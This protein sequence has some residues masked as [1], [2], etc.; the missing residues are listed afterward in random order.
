MEQLW[1]ESQNFEFALLGVAW[2]EEV[3]R[4]RSE[5]IKRLRQAKI[6]GSV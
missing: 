1:R 3:R 2:E 5:Q 4:E 6:N